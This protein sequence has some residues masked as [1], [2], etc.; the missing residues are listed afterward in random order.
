M[1]RRFLFAVAAILLSTTPVA[2]NEG[3]TYSWACGENA[4]CVESTE[5]LIA[6]KTCNSADVCNQIGCVAYCATGADDCAIEDPGNN[7][8]SSWWPVNS[9]E[10]LNAAILA[11]PA[12]STETVAEA[13]DSLLVGVLVSRLLEGQD[14]GFSDGVI[15]F[16]DGRFY[17]F[18]RE[19]D[20]S[21]SGL[22]TA[23]YQFKKHP[24]FAR[25]T[26]ESPSRGLDVFVTAETRSGEQRF[27]AFHFGE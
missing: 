26:I 23:A 3:R 22:V 8:N 7:P 9:P 10:F 24:A 25:I 20:V 19:V 1:L 13:F 2:A 11:A 16:Q 15:A 6:R 27:E 17:R 21:R 18:A 4:E 14:V 5:E 12:E